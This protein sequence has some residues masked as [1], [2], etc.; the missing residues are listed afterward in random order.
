MSTSFLNHFY[1]SLV[2]VIFLINENEKCFLWALAKIKYFYNFTLVNVYFIS[3][4]ENV[5]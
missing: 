4:H 1:F 3:S 2:L 5:F